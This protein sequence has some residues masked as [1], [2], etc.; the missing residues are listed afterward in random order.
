MSKNRILTIFKYSK[1]LQF[2]ARAL[3]GNTDKIL[4]KMALLITFHCPWTEYSEFINENLSQAA[5]TAEVTATNQQI[6]I[7][8]MHRN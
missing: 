2:Q 8:P 7:S 3:L 5:M 1:L 6:V 4:L